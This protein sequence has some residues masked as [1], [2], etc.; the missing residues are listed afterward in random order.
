MSARRFPIGLV[1]IA[2]VAVGFAVYAFAAQ[3]EVPDPDAAATATAGAVE[4]STPTAVGT[5]WS[6]FKTWDAADRTA[7]AAP[8][9]TATPMPT[10]TPEPM[11]QRGDLHEGAWVRVNAGEGDCL[12]ARNTP[13]LSAEW[14]IV[15]TC[16]PHGFEGYVTGEAQ[17]GDGHW[18]W[19]IA[20]AGWVAEDYLEYVRDVDIRART[21]PELAGKGR[22]AFTRRDAQSWPEIWVMNADGSEQRMVRPARAG[23]W[24]YDLAWTPDGEAVT[25]SVQRIDGSADGTWDL[26]IMPVDN[27]A[28]ETVV[29]GVFGASWARDG[30]TFATVADPYFEGMSGLKGI[31]AIVDLTTGERRLFGAAPFWH[32]L[33]PAFNHDGTKLLVTYANWENESDPGPRF[34]IWDRDGSEVARIEPPADGYYASPVWSPV[35]DRI[36]FHFGSAQGQ[37]Q[38]VVYDL[39]RRDIVAGARVPKASDKIGGKCGS[40]D[41]WA[42]SWSRD[43]SRVLYSFSMGDTGANGIW[44]WDVATGEQTLV[45][46]IS[47]DDASPGPDGYMVFA[48]AS[49]IFVASPAGGFPALLTDGTQPVWGP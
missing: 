25:F 19:Y 40:W 15:N 8:T 1:L 5:F 14:V 12:N 27:P 36:M 13:S 10:A 26:H 34:V 11:T 20:G 48:S 4:S 39:D 6:D 7:R 35:D 46:A 3:A 24:M 16:L 38:Y 37:P 21:L 22:I 31:P 41:M 18:W 29:E 42:A 44:T 45:P 17:H 30:A 33:P 49:H 9:T 32:Q 23:D 28:A 2:P 47:A 43:G